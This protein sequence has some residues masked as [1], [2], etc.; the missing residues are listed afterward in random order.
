MLRLVGESHTQ[1]D[2]LQ[3][4]TVVFDRVADRLR[5]GQVGEDTRAVE[6]WVNLITSQGYVVPVDERV[7]DGEVDLL[8]RRVAEL[9][10]QLG[11]EA[12]LVL[13]MQALLTLH[14]EAVGEIIARA[15]WI[16]ESG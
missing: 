4:K 15:G 6:H 10:A 2:T 14:V 13:L 12:E 16:W 7:T 8:A 9:N 5:T 1:V 11:S 3:P